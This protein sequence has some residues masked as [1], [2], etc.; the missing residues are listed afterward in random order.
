MSNK[1]ALII[2]PE[3]QQ[4]IRDIVL[5]IARD[6]HSP[7]A[8]L[9]L[10]DALQEGIESLAE[11]PERIKTV[12]EDPWREAGIRRLRVQNYYIYFIISEKDRTVK[13]MA[14]VYTK[15]NQENQMI[16]RGM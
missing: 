8:A 1:Y 9:R 15:R 3:A 13:I 5:Y 11:M 16:D 6:L 14:V 2:L 4:D 10:Q 12:D 7:G